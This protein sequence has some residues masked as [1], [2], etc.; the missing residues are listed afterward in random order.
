MQTPT[1][2]SRIKKPLFDLLSQFNRNW[3]Q[4]QNRLRLDLLEE[5][6]GNIETHPL[7]GELK[8]LINGKGGS[9]PFFTSGKIIWCTLAPNPSRLQKVVEQLQAW[10]LPSY[11]WQDR[12]DHIHR[13]PR[14]ASLSLLRG[15]LQQSQEGSGQ[16]FQE[17]RDRRCSL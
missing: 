8:N 2:L 11:G 9:L 17:G 12:L 10:I 1:N 16:V 14:T 5:E 3:E 15:M 7:K 4:H 13:H 6:I